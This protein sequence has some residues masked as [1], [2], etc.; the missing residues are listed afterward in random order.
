M[1]TTN[2]IDPRFNPA[3]Q[4]GYDG[5][6]DSTAAPDAAPDAPQGAPAGRARVTPAHEQVAQPAH[7]LHPTRPVAERRPTSSDSRSAANDDGVGHSAAQA[8]A[9]PEQATRAG[10]NPFLLGLLV[11]AAALIGCG[12]YLLQWSRELFMTNQ[13]DFVFAQTVVYTVPVILGLGIA[14]AI[15]VVFVYAVRWQG[16]SSRSS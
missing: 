14:T 6:G 4:R 16:G 2:R 9:E 5:E 1:G 13:V 7:S 15:G 12:V 8:E 3:F 10:V 11:V